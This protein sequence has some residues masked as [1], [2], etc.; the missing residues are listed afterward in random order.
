MIWNLEA[1]ISQDTKKFDCFDLGYPRSLE[2]NCHS[3]NAEQNG[4]EWPC[5]NNS[6]VHHS[7]PASTM[8]EGDTATDGNEF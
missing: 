6:N 7:V 4:T 1:K 2:Y 3:W 8:R 5:L